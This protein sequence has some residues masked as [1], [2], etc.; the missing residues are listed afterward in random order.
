MVQWSDATNILVSTLQE[1]MNGDKSAR[2]LSK[3]MSSN[4]V[5]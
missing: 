5:A 1:R 2:Q 4:T 3:L